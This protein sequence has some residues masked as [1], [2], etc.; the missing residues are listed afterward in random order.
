M[1]TFSRKVKDAMD[2]KIASGKATA[3][4]RDAVDSLLG[5]PL[6]LRKVPSAMQLGCAFHTAASR[7][8]NY[9][10]C[11]CQCCTL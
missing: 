1:A 8:A 7:C 10:I 9:V 6:K 5:P 3:D 2:L 11:F 4:E